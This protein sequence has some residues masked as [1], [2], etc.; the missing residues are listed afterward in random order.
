MLLKV[1][2]MP[3]VSLVIKMVFLALPWVMNSILVLIERKASATG[4]FGE[5]MTTH[6]S[7]EVT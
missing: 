4:D 5:L 6:G 7:F 1:L 2:P 3:W